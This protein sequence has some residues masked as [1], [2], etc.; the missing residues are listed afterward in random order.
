MFLQNNSCF[1]LFL[2]GLGAAEG[3][4]FALRR[5]RFHNFG[6]RRRRKKGKGWDGNIQ[7]GVM[8]R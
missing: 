8:D 4:C 7:K 2:I 3:V 6:R 1:L 5:N